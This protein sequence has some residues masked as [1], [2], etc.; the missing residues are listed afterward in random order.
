MKNNITRYEFQ[1]QNVQLRLTHVQ[2]QMDILN[3]QLVTSIDWPVTIIIEP[4]TQML[5]Q[6]FVERIPEKSWIE[7]AQDAPQMRL[8]R[9]QVDLSKNSEQFLKTGM[10]PHLF[11]KAEH[12]FSGPILVEVP[13]IDK[14]FG[15]W[16]AGIGLS[17]NIDALYRNRRKLK[18]NKLEQLD[19]QEKAA[20]TDEELLND[21]HEAYVNLYEA[22]IWLE[23]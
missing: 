15:F 3:H 4:D 5:K 10:R 22:Y 19:M 16:S 20:L 6:V 7:K 23:I 18:Q 17:Y 11:L 2:N 8:A 1:L 13:A 21:I 14:N 12:E 9:A